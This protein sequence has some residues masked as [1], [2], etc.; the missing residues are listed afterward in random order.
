MLKTSVLRDYVFIFVIDYVEI[1]EIIA[2]IVNIL[3]L[4]KK[5]QS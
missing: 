3:N 4:G 5:L 2:C 1:Y